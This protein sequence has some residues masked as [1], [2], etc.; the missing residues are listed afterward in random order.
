MQRVKSRVRWKMVRRKWGEKPPE[1]CGYFC[2]RVRG[3]H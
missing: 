3:D 2:G 1:E